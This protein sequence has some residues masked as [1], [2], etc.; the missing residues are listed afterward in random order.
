MSFF[1]RLF[2]SSEPIVVIPPTA[3]LPFAERV[4]MELD[5]LQSFVRSASGVLSGEVYSQ[6]RY[7]DDVVRPLLNYVKDKDV[8]ADDEYLLESAVTDYVPSPLKTFLQLP[9]EDQGEGGKGDLLLTRQYDTIIKN[10]Q[11][12]VDRIRGH[13]MDSLN[14]QAAF[15]DERFRGN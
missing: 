11:D 1:G 4:L 13:A 3:A 6:L 14:N 2:G 10:V 8:P 5:N 15:I 7:F 12:V 9:D